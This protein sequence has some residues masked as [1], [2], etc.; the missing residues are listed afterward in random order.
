MCYQRWRHSAGRPLYGNR[1]TADRPLNVK[2]YNI[3]LGFIVPPITVKTSEVIPPKWNG[4]FNARYTILISAH[5]NWDHLNYDYVIS[6]CLIAWALH[7]V[8]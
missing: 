5:I 1:Y 3:Y 4:L 2:H 6:V 7:Y 8:V